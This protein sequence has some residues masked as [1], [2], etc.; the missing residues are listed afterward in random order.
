MRSNLAVV[1]D[2]GPEREYAPGLPN[3]KPYRPLWTPR[4]I[5]GGLRT[6]RIFAAFSI[7]QSV[8]SSN[9]AAA[10]TTVAQT[11]PTA[12]PTKG[13]LLI[14]CLTFR[15]TGTVTEATS[16]GWTRISP[17]GTNSTTS[18]QTE[19]WYLVATS[20]MTTAGP[21]FTLPSSVLY[22]TVQYEV[23][24]WGGA[25]PTLDQ[26]GNTNNSNTVTTFTTTVSA[27]ITAASEFIAGAAGNAEGNT[28]GTVF[29]ASTAGGSATFGADI[30]QVNPGKNQEGIDA[31]WATS[32]ASG[33][34]PSITTNYSS[35]TNTHFSAVIATFKGVSPFKNSAGNLVMS[36]PHGRALR[37]R[38]SQWS[39]APQEMSSSNNVVPIVFSRASTLV[40]SGKRRTKR[41]GLFFRTSDEPRTIFQDRVIALAESQQA[42]GRLRGP[43]YWLFSYL[44]YYLNTP[45]LKLSAESWVGFGKRRRRGGWRIVNTVMNGLAPLGTPMK[46]SAGWMVQWLRRPLRRRLGALWSRVDQ[47]NPMLSSSGSNNPQVEP[48][49]FH[50]R[51]RSRV[52]TYVETQTSFWDQVITLAATQQSAGRLRQPRQPRYP[53][54]ATA[55]NPLRNS[56]GWLVYWAKR[57][58]RRRSGSWVG[59]FDSANAMLSASGASP[60]VEPAASW[61]SGGRRRTR[62]GVVR[63][64]DVA[65]TI[66][67]DVAIA[68]TRGAGAT[69]RLR[70]PRYWFV[71]WMVTY[72]GG[73][74]AN[75]LKNMAGYLVNWMRR[76]QRRRA[77]NLPRVSDQTNFNLNPAGGGNPQVEPA[78]NLIPGGRR[79]GRQVRAPGET[80]TSFWDQVLSTGA[81]QQSQGRLRGPR[82]WLPVLATA[83][84][85]LKNMAG[86]LIQWLRRPSR[87][88]AGFYPGQADRQS[89]TLS[90]TATPSF[91][92]ADFSTSSFR[93][94][95]SRRRVGRSQRRVD[96]GATGLLQQAISSVVGVWAQARLKERR[97]WYVNLVVVTAPI[98]V[99]PVYF[100][101]K[102][103]ARSG[104]VVAL[105]RSGIVSVLS[106]S[107]KTRAKQ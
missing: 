48:A 71:S 20:G 77:G 28:A 22:E 101:V 70:G 84:N 55:P 94:G 34:S 103:L 38:A 44:S 83:P 12:A 63:S 85:P 18:S 7:V 95:R 89:T 42:S 21:T 58:W 2:P 33:T 104:R 3:P 14:F 30:S 40:V 86:N 59:P 10:A 25:T 24:G 100:I 49:V 61:I 60:Q 62:Q 64:T 16:Q 106:R 43:R 74:L 11:W 80:R 39:L 81:S 26:T 1:W 78:S 67:Q 73:V 79:R 92:P 87:R 105:T 37:R 9:P 29:N 91:N 102:A 52:R 98:I 53:S 99:Q 65:P 107:G 54:T 56:A 50:I 19:Q 96:S 66:Y 72:S 13:N 93:S 41:A 47:G 35:S 90:Q 8:A 45:P 17:Q 69:G 36:T 75:P 4:V 23:S 5:P 68:A 88:R 27:T 6:P 82:P 97:P 57:A 31:A 51:R 32:G 76:P 15:T 46:N